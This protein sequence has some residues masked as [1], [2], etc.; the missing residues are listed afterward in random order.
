MSFLANLLLPAA[1]LA[2]HTGA[3]AWIAAHYT[4]V[5]RRF[6]ALLFVGVAVLA[7]RR[8]GG[9]LPALRR[10]ATPAT[11]AP[12]PLA[13]FAACIVTE[14]LLARWLDLHLVRASA[15]VLGGYALVGLYAPPATWRAGLPWI[16]LL[17]LTLPFG[18]F[19]EVYLGFP[20]RLF[21]A[22]LVRDGLDFLGIASLSRDTI[23]VLDRPGGTAA[24]Q[25][26]APCAG[27]RSLW[28]AGVFLLAAAC[29]EGRRLDRWFGAAVVVTGGLLLAANTLRV[30]TLVVLGAVLDAP[31]IA[32]AVHVPLGLLGFAWAAAAGWLV[33]RQ[34][35][36]TTGAAAPSPASPTPVPGLAP[37]LAASLVALATLVPS[38]PTAPAAALPF[39]LALPDHLEA[40]PFV[41]TAIAPIPAEVDYFAGVDVPP[42]AKWRFT[43]VGRSSLA[44][45][46]LVVPSRAWRA[47]HLPSA[48]LLGQG[49]TVE[50][51]WT[52]AI[53]PSFD[54]R[55]A[56]VDD[57]AATA[58]WWFQAPGRTTE[59]LSVRTWAA[60]SGAEDRWVLVS[61]LL[62]GTIAPLTLDPLVRAL[63]RSVHAGLDPT[64]QEAACAPSVPS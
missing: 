43:S 8:F 57:G 1:W 20:A 33:L 5:D 62:E 41:A 4:H 47:H 48:C 49:H 2:T 58:V 23:L 59:D 7:W 52:V 24:V 19:S 18:A 16:G 36:G 40:T 21:T 22:G 38:P 34:G 17:T 25:I 54:V 42:P 30:A 6:E 31:A 39:T 61:M 29:V 64:A 26:D 50:G 51:P 10:L 35:P 46:L 11:P 45:T 28:S 13:L 44:G 9:P 37:L 60:L 14:L 15:F 32:S 53:A 56:R 27:V 3:L 63:H 55:V 12:A